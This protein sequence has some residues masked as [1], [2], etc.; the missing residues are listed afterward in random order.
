MEGGVD[1]SDVV[2]LFEGMMSTIIPWKDI[3]FPVHHEG[4]LT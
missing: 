1:R 3:D 2:D 4:T